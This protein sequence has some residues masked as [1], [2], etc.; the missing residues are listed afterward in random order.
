MW[1]AIRYRPAQALVLLALSALITA[2]AV[3]APL[4]DRAMLH[5]LTRSTLDAASAGTTA[6]QVRSVSRASYSADVPAPAAATPDELDTLLPDSAR[7]WFGPRVDGTSVLVTESA[8]TSRSPTGTLQW[9]AGACEHVEWVAGGCPR[10]AL[11]IAVSAADR[12]NFRLGVGSTVSAE[13]EATSVPGPKPTVQLRVTGVY[14]QVRD[15]YWADQLLTGLSGLISKSPPYLPFHDVWL[16]AAPTFAGP[17]SAA[18]ADPVNTVTYPLDRPATGVDRMVRV[19]PV[20]SAMA[21][22]GRPELD[23]LGQPVDPAGAVQ[24]DVQSGLLDLSAAVERGRDQALVTVPLL[25]IPL[26]L[27]ALFVLGLTLGAAVEQ[28]RPEVALARLR[29]A[30]RVGGRR[31]VLAEL[32]PVVLAGV[33]VGVALALGLAVGARRTLLDDSSPLELGRA[34]WLAIAGAAL[35]LTAV[36]WATVAAGTRDHVA[37]LLR[38]V[39]VRVPG[40]RFGV[41]DLLVVAGSGTAVAAFLTGDLD[42]PLALAAPGLLGLVAGLLLAHLI[43]PV[44]TWAGRRLTARGSYATALALLAVARRPSTR[45]VVTVVTVAS[46]L[47]VFSTYAIGVGGRNRQLVAERENGA[48]MVADITGTEVPRARAAVAA[49][50]DGHATLVTRISAGADAFRTTLAVDPEEFGRIA[51]F[52]DTDPAA[53]PWSGLRIPTGRRLALTGPAVSL[54]VTPTSFPLAPRSPLSLQIRVRDAAGVEKVIGLGDVP[55]AGPAR[56]TVPM[57][58]VPGCTVVGFSLQESYVDYRG[59]VAISDVRVPGGSTDLPGTPDDWRGE[60]VEGSSI[61]AVAGPAGALAVELQ[62]NGQEPAVLTSRWLPETLPAVVVGAAGVASSAGTVLGNSL[63]GVNREFTGIA[64]L[65]RAP[66]VVRTAA[67][68]DLDL[69]SRYGSRLGKTARMQVWFDTEDP[70]VLD[71]V[72]AALA[73]AGVEVAGVRRLS[74]SRAAYDASVPAW[75]LQLGVVAAVAG[76]LIAALV[77]VLLVAATWRRRARDLACLGMTGVPRRGLGRVAVGEQLPTVLLAVLVGGGCGLLGAVYALPS[78]PLFAQPRPASELD[79]AVPWAAVL[80]ALAGAL[81]LLGLVAW[82][83]GRAVARA[84]ERLARVR[85]VL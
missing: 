83:C 13:E 78:V 32:L 57:P 76:L 69:L 54:L 53:V 56:L 4:Y 55:T 79:L 44:A 17:G 34:F 65:P 2:A 67:L 10:D 63:D 27:L 22:A 48:P 28:R 21:A 51:L 41:L 5:T 23:D 29:G 81:V 58:C 70:A 49:A 72:R 47:L 73:S 52:P 6:V 15:P 25:M 85:E 75:S 84:G 59:T 3:L 61:D 46:A 19:G 45:R 40:W 8:R 30:G 43:V 11:D 24:G 68:V 64:E 39:P 77:L 16:T 14:R 74:E 18:W 12:D 31:L 1:A 33:P 50:G 7:S 37:A 60:T 71:R 38:S 9:R 42:G 35:L 36:A 62:G 66:A 26:G 80:A 82:L 20:V